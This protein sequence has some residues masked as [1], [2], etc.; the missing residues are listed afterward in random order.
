MKY[1][2]MAYYPT[3]NETYLYDLIYETFDDAYMELQSLQPFNMKEM[4]LILPYNET[5]K[6][7]IK[8]TEHWVRI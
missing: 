7:N 8:N 1:I 2:I 6:A 5:C 3:T 4:Y